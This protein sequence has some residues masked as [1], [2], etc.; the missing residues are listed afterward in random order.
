[1]LRL[2]LDAIQTI[3]AIASHGSLS[4]AA[5]QLH[6]VPSTISY[7][8]AKL[9]EQLGMRLF[10]RLGQGVALT[11]VGEELLN[12]GRWLVQAAGDLESRLRRVAMGFEAELRLI[13]D[14]VIPGAA[15]I[16]DI[17]AFEALQCGTRLRLATETMTG[18]WEALMDGRAVLFMAAGEGPSGGGYQAQPVGSI[19]F[20]FC[21]A[22]S[23]PLAQARQPLA[24]EELLRHTAIVVADSARSLPSRTIGL[25]SGQ[26]R[27]T[28]GDI[29][30]K[31]A[32]QATGLGHGFLPRALV[33]RELAEGRLIELAVAE[34]K[35]QE[36][37]WL[38]WRPG[39]N[40]AALQWWQ[41]RL[42]RPLLPALLQ[43]H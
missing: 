42:N 18:S 16:P 21:V 41:A 11:R 20:A 4:A 10:E 3:D 35:P 39:D 29:R 26:P 8:V 43:F 5:E 2:T 32:L 14:A 27:L 6:K 9:E 37:F 40:G 36:S 34:A 23:H 38:A 1:M 19:D 7:T 31:I 33:E 25:L 17:A 13:Y 30:T 12:E 22:P 28:V 24:R 15:L